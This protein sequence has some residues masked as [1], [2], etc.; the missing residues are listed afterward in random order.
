MPR[1]TRSKS[2]QTAD[3]VEICIGQEESN[4][5]GCY[6]PT[7]QRDRAEELENVQFCGGVDKIYEPGK[8]EDS[9][10]LRSPWC[11]RKSFVD[12]SERRLYRWHDARF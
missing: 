9:R 12:T 10:E 5:T 3:T 6:G 2:I 1:E 7:P 8:W 4:I 11:I